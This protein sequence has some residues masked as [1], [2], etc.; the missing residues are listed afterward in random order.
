LSFS[1]DVAGEFDSVRRFAEDVREKYPKFSFILPYVFIFWRRFIGKGYMYI[2]AGDDVNERLW[3]AGGD[4]VRDI[5]SRS[6]DLEEKALHIASTGSGDC[7]TVTD[8]FFICTEKVGNGKL[9]VVA[10][11]KMFPMGFNRSLLHM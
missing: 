6:F 1:I 10:S 7:V 4:E 3:N 5:T 8:E 2:L 9:I 11:K